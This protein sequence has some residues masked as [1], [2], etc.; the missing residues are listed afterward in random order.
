MCFGNWVFYLLALFKGS[1]IYVILFIME[2]LVLN[3]WGI[4]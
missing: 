1:F 4:E 3:I 2:F